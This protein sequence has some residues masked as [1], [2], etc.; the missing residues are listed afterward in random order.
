MKTHAKAFITVLAMAIGLQCEADTLGKWFLFG[1][2]PLT[3]AVT[4][5][6]PCAVYV[7][8]KVQ[9]WMAGG[10]APEYFRLVSGKGWRYSTL[11][12]EASPHGIGVKVP[13]A[14]DVA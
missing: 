3:V 8:G 7:D 14:A 6:A 5:A 2:A 11:V 1:D 12:S 13:I 9:G 10:D 4:S